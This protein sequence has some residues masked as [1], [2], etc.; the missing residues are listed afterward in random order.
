MWIQWLGF[1]V[2]VSELGLRVSSLYVLCGQRHR[3]L[4]HK[5]TKIRR[6]HEHLAGNNLEVR[7]R[8]GLLAIVALS[9]V[10]STVTLQGVCKTFNF[11]RVL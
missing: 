2:G 9:R 10:A 6:M 3:R 4:N 1:G 7:I 5:V 8:Q 11:W